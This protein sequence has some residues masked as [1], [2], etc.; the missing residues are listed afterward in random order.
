MATHTAMAQGGDA[1]MRNAL[2]QRLGIIHY[3]SNKERSWSGQMRTRYTD[4]QVHEI[5]N[6]G[7]IVHLNDFVNNAR[8]MAR[9]SSQAANPQP[10]IQKSPQ[11]T[12]PKM[13]ASKA[14]KSDAV[15]PQDAQPNPEADSTQA[16]GA[17]QPKDSVSES[18]K[19][20]L[21]ELVGETV[22]D[23]LLSLNER[24]CRLSRPLRKS[25]PGVKIPAIGDKAKRSR[26][27]EQVRRVF[28]GRI[29]TVTLSD[30]SIKA[31]Q[32]RGSGRQGGGDRAASNG[33]RNSR[34]NP[35]QGQ[36]Q[37]QAPGDGAF[38]HF[39]LYKENKDTMDALNHMARILR[40]PAK[41]FGVAGTKDRRAVT[42]QR[43]SIKN[44][45]PA[46]MLI[47]NERIHQIKI[48][49]FKFSRLPIR[50][51]D[52]NGNEFIIVLKNC[53]FQ[54]T[55]LLSFE[56]RLDVAQ[57]TVQSALA[58]IT[59][60]GFL[61]YYGTQRFGTHEI[62]TQEVGMK[63]LQDDFA[64]ATNALL[65]YDPQ[66]LQESDDDGQLKKSNQEDIGRARACKTFLE[67][68]SA[69]EA[70]EFLPPRCHVE[71]T[72]FQH[73]GKT[74]TDFPG[75]VMA[76]TRTMRTMYV[77]A[78]QSLV[79]NF[80][81]SKRWELFGPQVIKGDL[82]LVKVKSQ[83]QIDQP[84]TD[85]DPVNLDEDATTELPAGVT[86]HIITESEMKDGK[87]SIYDI[88]LPTPGWDV[89]YPHNEIGEF[90]AEFMAKPENGGLDPHKMQ[91]RQRDF[92]LPG[93]YRKLMGKLKRVPAVT[94]QGYSDDLEQL[95]PTDLDNIRSRKAK[96]EEQRLARQQTA[97][98]SWNDFTKS[99][100]QNELEETKSRIAER[101]AEE[102]LPAARMNDTWVQTNV[103]GSNKRIK[104]AKHSETA[105]EEMKPTS[106]GAAV[107]QAPD[108][109]DKPIM[110]VDVEML[111]TNDPQQN[112]DVQR[113]QVRTTTGSTIISMLTAQ[114]D[115]NHV[116][117]E[118]QVV[119]GQRTSTNEEQDNEERE[120]ET[121]GEGASSNVLLLPDDHTSK[122][123]IPPVDSPR[124]DPGTPQP[125]APSASCPT[126]VTDHA[127]P[128][129]A[130]ATSIDAPKPTKVAVILR[131]ALDTSQ[132]ATMVVRE[133]QGAYSQ[134]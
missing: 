12:E 50:L 62:G 58:Q 117:L 86:A 70:L 74:P 129:D 115:D 32:G 102:P 22:T 119:A 110:T 10:T 54:G 8:E 75:A 84:M 126:S 28:E 93:S 44:R 1:S 120:K 82:V 118:S 14:S 97:A 104:I 72:L 2:E 42:S 108:T 52:H 111:G 98:S 11:A 78:Y 87:Y 20:A 48:G 125:D 46:S 76:I 63:I 34:Q 124:P 17:G 101:Q 41:F 106:E 134:E 64:G 27:H 69:E 132:Y 29:E 60:R 24:I 116:Q 81:A 49:D 65:S 130:S 31:T 122:T 35:G 43:V 128:V 4:F 37:R 88:V 9:A 3:V 105:R 73:L 113:D 45:S 40:F 23:D 80:A 53:F 16:E 89:V 59:Q 71:R 68:H 51:N 38:L 56:D 109:K 33:S 83:S 95:V 5:S 55:E 85:E 133:L 112:G 92:S 39:T 30:G 19:R 6:D 25:D 77:H 21:I 66:L 107:V 121:T 96:E 61:N 91:R 26:V 94:V 13:V 15:A 90:Y 18:D 57:S 47:I 99:V 131:F 123:G 67:T 103:D 100:R 127:P 7:E 36:S 79:W 114:P